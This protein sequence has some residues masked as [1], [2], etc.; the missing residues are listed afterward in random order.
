MKN[1][2][3]EMNM[4]SNFEHEI[5]WTEEKVARFWNFYSTF[6][7]ISGTY[8]SKQV[9]DT[10]IRLTHKYA[11]LSGNVLDYGCGPGFLMEY[12]LARKIACWGLDFAES[13]LKLVSEKFKNNPYFK[14]VYYADKLPTS[15]S[16][17]EFDLVFLLE[18][19]EHILPDELEAVFQE[20]N[21]I[22][23]R[24]GKIIITTPNNENLDSKKVM[25]P[26]CGCIFHPVQHVRSWTTTSLPQ[27]MES[28]GYTKTTCFSTTLRPLNLLYPLWKIGEFINRKPPVNLIYIGEKTA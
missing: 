6:A 5:I 13:N 24:G 3:K 2:K 12:L 28:V 20:I 4:K 18:T 26:D 22:T 27:F 14:G 8:F 19:I 23:K 7:P 21:R 11:S 1:K 9:G 15:I 25:C 16:N 10:V 17:G